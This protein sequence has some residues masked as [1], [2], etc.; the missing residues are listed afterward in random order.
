MSD[1]RSIYYSLFNVFCIYA[2]S[3]YKHG[4]EA[5]I[6]L[7]DPNTVE[8]TKMAKLAFESSQKINKDVAQELSMPRPFE[9]E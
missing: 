4:V 1:F 3:A 9:F 7:I 8:V 5:P 6:F 2:R